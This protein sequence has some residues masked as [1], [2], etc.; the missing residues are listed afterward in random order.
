MSFYNTGNPVPSIDPRDLDDNAKHIDELTNS[1]ELTFVDRFG[2]TRRTLAGIEADNVL[3]TTPNGSGVVGHTPDFAG[4]L[5][6]TVKDKLSDTITSADVGAI[7]DGNLYPVSDWY[8]IPATHYRGYANLAA[9]QADYPHVTSGTQQIDWAALQLGFSGKQKFDILDGRYRIDGNTLQYSAEA[10]FSGRGK[11]VHGSGRRRCLISN[12]TTSHPLINFGD[13]SGNFDSI[14]CG[15]FGVSLQGNILSTAGVQ[16]I[17]DDDDGITGASRG[18]SIDEVRVSNVGAGPALRV[19]AWSLKVGY[20]EVEDNFRGVQIGNHVYAATFLKFYNVSSVN[21]AVYIA[22]TVT[23]SKATQIVFLNPVLQG[24]GAGGQAVY[25]GGA[26]GVMFIGPYVENLN[27]AATR[28]FKFGANN[29]SSRVTDL[30][31]TKGTGPDLVDIIDTESPSLTV[32]GVDGRGNVRSFVKITGGNLGTTIRKLEHPTG[33][34]SVGWVDDQSTNKRTILEMPK[35]PTEAYE[36]PGGIKASTGEMAF[37][38][39]NRASGAIQNFFQN[40]RLHF[41]ADTTGPNLQGAGTTLSVFSGVGGT[42]ATLRPEGLRLGVTNV[43][44]FSRVSGSP[45]GVETADPGSQCAV[46]TG[47]A[48]GGYIKNNTGT[49]NTGWVLQ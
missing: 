18:V 48:A 25:C 14:D 23:T 41:G 21:E 34:R 8:T 35:D 30:F 38:L 11:Q 31:Y 7:G 6:R 47:A 36:P 16:I 43:R 29:R 26:A 22:D 13:V 45:E 40:G 2:T 15:L 10:D 24:C 12:L 37:W 9:V 5:V 28:A 1:T 42:Y 17:G 49:G 46:Q 32:D 3:L 33:T 44:I 39:M 4:G 19:S 27:A 20:L